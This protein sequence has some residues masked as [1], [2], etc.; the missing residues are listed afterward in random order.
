MSQSFLQDLFSFIIFSLC[1]LSFFS[2]GAK[3]TDFTS[4]ARC[5]SVV[6]VPAQ[7]KANNER[8]CELSR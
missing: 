4:K 8:P 6:E 3:P 5:K 7:V 1:V 2:F